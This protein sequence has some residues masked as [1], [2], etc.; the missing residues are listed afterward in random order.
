MGSDQDVP[1]VWTAGGALKV[2]VL[3]DIHAAASPPAGCK[4]A[5]VDD[6]LE[7]LQEARDIAIRER[8]SVTVFTGDLFHLKRNVPHGLVWKIMSILKGWPGQK[9]AIVG[10]HDLSEEGIASISK[11]PIGVLFK[12]GVLTWL[13]KDYVEKYVT[14]TGIG[15]PEQAR[16]EWLTIQWSPANYYNGIDDDPANLG[17][18]RVPDVDWAVKV[19][20]ASLSPKP[21]IFPHITYK[22]VPTEGMDAVLHGHIH[23]DV[24]Y[25][26]VNGCTFVNYGSLGRVARS[27]D[28][29]H[30][31][32]RLC[33]MTITKEEIT[34]EGIEL[35]S[36]VDTQD[37]YYDIDRGPDELSSSMEQFAKHVGTVMQLEE[38]S[39]DEAL[40]GL[41]SKGLNAEAKRKLV[42]YLQKAGL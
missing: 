1:R 40:A 28:N 4:P 24:G 37:L 36:A 35:K 29:L 5:Y 27:A 41:P 20:H 39:I 31:T 42:S 14:L 32:P 25:K 30:R 6:V 11:Q 13:E 26:T 7:M 10:N 3:N 33:L 18:T 21:L 15:E 22:Q 9:L 19:V 38:S 16:S 2:L 17:L 34:Y 12:A 23:T 8:V